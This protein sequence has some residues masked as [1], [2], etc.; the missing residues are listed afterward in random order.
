VGFHSE[1]FLASFFAA[2]ASSIAY[3]L[4]TLHWIFMTV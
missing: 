4:D 2:L 3:L 1:D